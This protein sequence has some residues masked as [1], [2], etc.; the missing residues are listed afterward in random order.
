[1]KSLQIFFFCLL[2][3][4][5][6]SQHLKLVKPEQLG[7]DSR[8]LHYADEI[9]LKAIENSEIPGAVLAVVYKGKM[10]YLKAYGNKQ[11]YPDTI[12]MDVNTVFDMASVSKSM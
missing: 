12:P 5:A 4:S 7:I 11:V 8:H 6:F 2:S 3:L 1:M 9:I 10:A